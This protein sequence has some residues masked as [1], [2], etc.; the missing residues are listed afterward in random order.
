LSGVIP[1]APHCRKVQKC[2]RPGS[3]VTVRNLVTEEAPGY[4]IVHV[5]EWGETVV[6]NDGWRIETISE[7]WESCLC[8][9]R[10]TASWDSNSYRRIMHGLEPYFKPSL[11]GFDGCQERFVWMAEEFETLEESIKTDV[12]WP[13]KA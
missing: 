12:G 4:A 1:S 6:V 7:G 10:V 13:M 5:H 11:E 3:V 9:R 8:K 2:W